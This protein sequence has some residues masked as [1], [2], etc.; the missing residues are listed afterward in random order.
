VAETAFQSWRRASG[1]VEQLA[2]Q[3]AAT[4]FAAFKAPN[5]KAELAEIERLGIGAMSYANYLAAR[6][7]AGGPGEICRP[8][9]N[10]EWLRDLA[11]KTGQLNHLDDLLAKSDDAETHWRDVSGKIRHHR[12]E[13]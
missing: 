11:N 3:L 9:K 4:Y 7:N 2:A 12:Y 8:I 10:R 6:K 5:K 13:A 1:P